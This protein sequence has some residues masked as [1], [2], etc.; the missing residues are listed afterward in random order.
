MRKKI[1]NTGNLKNLVSEECRIT[2]EDLDLVTGGS[3]KSK[4]K[5]K[6]L[7]EKRKDHGDAVRGFLRFLIGD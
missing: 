2:E 7:K 6:K 4:K 3:R 1:Q 5:A